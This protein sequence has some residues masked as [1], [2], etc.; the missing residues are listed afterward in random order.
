[1]RLVGLRSLSMMMILISVSAFGL[2]RAT[3]DGEAAGQPIV[4][5]NPESGQNALHA[6]VDPS[7]GGI[8]TFRGYVTL[9]EAWNP[10]TQFVFVELQAE[11]EGW[12]VTTIPL[13]TLT[14][15]MMEMSFSV[16]IR[17]PAGYRTSGLDETKIMTISGTWIYE[18]ETRRGDVEPLEILIY[19]DQF[20]QYSM[21]CQQ[22]FVHTSPGGEFDIEI[23]IT[24]E[25]NGDDEITLSIDGR[26]NMEANGWAFVF[27]TTKW[28]LPHK[29]SIKIPVHV[30]TPKKWEGWRNNIVVVKF[31]LQSDQAIVSH[32]ISEPASYS[33]FV[34][35]R[36]VSVP[37]FEPMVFLLAVFIA[38]LLMMYR[39]RR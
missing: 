15:S 29:E 23:E 3:D 18:P 13:L 38:S 32:S 10:D 24:N 30:A 19:I 6:Q 5:V 25:G 9:T 1:M 8:V 37:G 20:Y 22:S 14:S 4:T 31:D 21:R 26:E 16:S 12:E 2:L 39:R 11:V 34:L 17:V 33:I 28:A 27:I 35:Q 36:G 7:T